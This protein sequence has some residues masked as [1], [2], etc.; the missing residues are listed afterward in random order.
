MLVS[1]D[2]KMYIEY[3]IDNTNEKEKMMAITE[4]AKIR[5][6]NMKLYPRYLMLGFDLLFFYG[7]RVMFLSEVKGITDSQILLSA[8]VYALSMVVMQVPATLITS[9]IGYKNSAIL[10]N[11]INIIWAILIMAMQSYTGLVVAQILS[12]M[13]FALKYVSESNLLSTSI[14]EMA[15]YQRN[16]IFTK[17]DKKGF[18]RYCLISAIS[19]ILSGFL[20]NINPYIP[21]TLCLICLIAATIISFNFIDIKTEDN[22]ASSFKDYI[23]ELKKGYKFITKSKRLRALF[24]MTGTIW[25]IIVLLDTYQLTLLQD[26]GATSVQIGFIFAALELTKGLFSNS[27][28]KFN[29]KFKNRSLTNIL[30]T[31]ATGFIF[32]GIIATTKIPFAAKFSLII[33]I[34][35]ILG[36]AN[37]IDQILAKKYINNFTTTKILPPIYSAKCIADNLSRTVMTLLGAGILSIYNINYAMI[38]MGIAIL[39]I[40]LILTIYSRDKLGLKPNEYTQKDI[41]KR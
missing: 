8:T 18:F 34:L 23:K 28:Q 2:K 33:I 5:K 15:T 10:G 40:A 30:M 22:S 14:P 35:M 41:Y 16:E 37:A 31:F 25:G 7:I 36:A 38:I 20:Y 6:H 11:I 4:D 1:F 9:K 13:G 17:I 26:I 3:Y 32:A 24:L 19:T 39:F 27:A 12:G 29:K 21:I